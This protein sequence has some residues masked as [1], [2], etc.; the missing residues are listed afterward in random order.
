[1]LVAVVGDLRRTHTTTV[2]S[3][4]SRKVSFAIL[5]TRATSAPLRNPVSGKRCSQLSESRSDSEISRAAK[6]ARLKTT[7]HLV[8]HDRHAIIAPVART[9][10]RKACGLSQAR[11]NARS[12]RRRSVNDQSTLN[13]LRRNA[14]LARSSRRNAIRLSLRRRTREDAVMRLSARHARG[15]KPD[16]RRKLRYSRR[17]I[18][19]CWR[20]SSTNS[21]STT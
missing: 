9:A 17:A 15:M 11:R 6:N 7:V 10:A 12:R 4:A 13:P 14:A 21:V 3:I 19:A 20:H 2:R 5:I 18:A 1:M 8:A 16:A